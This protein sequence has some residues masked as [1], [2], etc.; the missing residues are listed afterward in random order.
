MDKRY[1]WSVALA[2]IAL[3]MM[4]VG[5][6]D[7]LEGFPLVLMAGVCALIAAGLA[8]RRWFRFLAWGLGL[9]VLGCIALVVL[10]ARGGFGGSSKTPMA[11]GLVAAPYPVGGILLLAGIVLMIRYLLKMRRSPG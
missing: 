11:W 1:G 6:L 10:S 9:A 8:A 4:V 2:F 7:P 5:V 3:T